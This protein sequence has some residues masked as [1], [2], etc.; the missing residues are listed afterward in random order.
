MRKTRPQPSELACEKFPAKL[1][2]NHMP[3]TV[4][5]ELPGAMLAISD[6]P[7]DEKLS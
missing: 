7:I 3:I 1:V 2:E 5:R 6:R 4:E